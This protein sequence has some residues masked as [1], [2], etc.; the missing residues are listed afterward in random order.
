MIPDH[1]GYLIFIEGTYFGWEM[2]QMVWSLMI[3]IYFP[4]QRHNSS[5][6]GTC[7]PSVTFYNNLSHVLDRIVTV[8]NIVNH[9]NSGGGDQRACSNTNSYILQVSECEWQCS[10]L[11]CSCGSTLRCVIVRGKR[12]D[13]IRP[14]VSRHADGAS[15]GDTWYLTVRR[16]LTTA[17]PEA[18]QVE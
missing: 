12:Y 7:V 11:H 9:Q 15:Y 17:E 3:C 10:Q 2:G 6:D 18:V 14:G 13:L 5:T 16:G 4:F 1:M 8:D